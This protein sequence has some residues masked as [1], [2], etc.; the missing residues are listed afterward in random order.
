MKYKYVYENE[1]SMFY[2]SMERF[3]KKNQTGF[4]KKKKFPIGWLGVDTENEVHIFS[5][6]STG[7]K[8]GFL[9]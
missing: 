1:R 7:L 8:R 2:S 9:K 6:I 5:K 3:S 4:E